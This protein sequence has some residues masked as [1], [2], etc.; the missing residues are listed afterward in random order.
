M[1]DLMLIHSSFSNGFCIEVMKTVHYL[2]NRLSIINENHGKIILEEV[3]T[4][5]DQNL[6]EPNPYSKIWE[7]SSNYYTSTEVNKVRL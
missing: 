1:K 3:W 6:S 4:E 5:K 2:C 7:P